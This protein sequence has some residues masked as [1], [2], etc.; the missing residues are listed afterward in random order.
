VGYDAFPHYQYIVN[1]VDTQAPTILGFTLLGD[2][3]H[4][5]VTHGSSAQSL[6]RH[7]VRARKPGISQVWDGKHGFSCIGGIS[8]VERNLPFLLSIETL[9]CN[10][11]SLNYGKKLC[12]VSCTEKFL[13]PMSTK[14]N[15]Q[16]LR[17]DQG[18][19]TTAWVDPQKIQTTISTTI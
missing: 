19:K 1:Q 18:T 12:M 8:V 15:G 4:W 11:E 10:R 3:P 7:Y 5:A 6:H 9:T 14:V 2:H 17:I 16:H 13:H